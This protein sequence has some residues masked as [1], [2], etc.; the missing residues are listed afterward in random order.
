MSGQNVIF[1]TFVGGWICR[2]RTS[3]CGWKINSMLL[4]D[5][6]LEGVHTCVFMLV[7]EH[8]WTCL[9]CGFSWV[10]WHEFC[11]AFLSMSFWPSWVLL[12][13]FPGLVLALTQTNTSITL[14]FILGLSSI[15]SSLLSK[16]RTIYL[17]TGSSTHFW[18]QLQVQVSIVGGSGSSWPLVHTKHYGGTDEICPSLTI[19][20]YNSDL[21][22][23]V[24]I[25]LFFF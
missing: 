9:I 10:N 15:F 2:F 7:P 22:R 12:G 21:L 6:S 16:D 25:L 1:P 17:T 3:R 4:S 20:V 5:A 24:K 18:P 11:E 23:K 19:S 14:P 13:L 8:M